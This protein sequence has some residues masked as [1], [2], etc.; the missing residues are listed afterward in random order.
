[1]SYIRTLLKLTWVE[2]KLFAREPVTMVFTFAFPIIVL[3]VLMEVFGN[4]PDQG[5]DMVVFRGVGPANYYVPAYIGLVIASI[6]LISLP[7]HLAG[8]REQGVLRRFRASSV[9]IWSVFGAQMLVSFIIA[10]LGAVLLTIVA[11]LTKDIHLPKSIGLLVPAFVLSTFSFAAIGV[12]LGAVLPTARAA[13][14][15][16]LL[17]FFVMMFVAGAGPPPEVMTDILNHVGKV[18]P[19][20]HVIVLLQDAWLGFDWNG[21]ASGIVAGFMVVSALLSA[22]FFRWE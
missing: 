8:Y 2:L 10:V 1:M 9:S 3:F 14:G 17:L 11:M 12:F 21:V 16:G 20:K 6:G 19:L 4:T 18:M 22:R 5:G 15:V 13:Q 7:V